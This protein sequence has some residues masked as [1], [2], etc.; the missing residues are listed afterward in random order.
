MSIEV[1]AAS[2]QDADEMAALLNRIIAIG[3]TTAYRDRFDT[4]KIMSEFIAP[5]LAIACHIAVEDQ[6]VCGFQALLWCDPTWPGENRL[7]ADWAVIATYVDPEIHG[8]GI[9]R[10]LF[11]STAEAARKAGVS[12]IDATIRKENTGGIAYYS[13]MG[14]EDYRS[15]DETVSKRFAPA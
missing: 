13:R 12:F 6:K 1:R 5:E 15:S 9:G 2:P 11:E 3:G 14:F 4:K 10:A 8:K 7:P